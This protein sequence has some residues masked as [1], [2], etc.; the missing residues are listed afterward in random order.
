MHKLAGFI[1]RW[2][3]PLERGARVTFERAELAGEIAAP[4]MIADRFVQML[5]FKTIG[6]NWEMLDPHG[7]FGEARSA[8]TNL[9]AATATDMLQPSTDWLSEGQAQQCAS[10]FVDAFDRASR[11]ILSNRYDGLWNP[12]GSGDIE[13]AFVGYDDAAIALLL[14]EPEA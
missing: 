4:Y 11:T 12:I 1:E 10:G 6:H 5:G 13:W 3:S 14:L 8:L 2:R 9:A 7:A